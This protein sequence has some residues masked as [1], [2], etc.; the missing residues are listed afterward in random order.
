[1]EIDLS[2]I[3][4]AYNISKTMNKLLDSILSVNRD[5]Y[6]IIIINDGSSDNTCEIAEKYINKYG[7]KIKL[8]NKENGGHGSVFNCAIKYASGRY[9]KWIDGDDWVVT[10]NLDRI[11]GDL[12]KC[13]SDLIIN[14]YKIYHEDTQKEEL[15][16]LWID[17]DGIKTGQEINFTGVLTKIK[18]FGFHAIIYKTKILREHNIK[19]TE[20]VFYEDNEYV[21]YPLPYVKTVVFYEEPLYVYRVGM[22][23]QSTSGKNMWMRRDQLRTVTEKLLKYSADLPECY[24]DVKDYIERAIEIALVD[25]YYTLCFESEYAKVK[26]Y[27]EVRDFDR[28]LRLNYPKIYKMNTRKRVRYFWMAP[29]II[30]FIVLSKRKKRQ[31]MPE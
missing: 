30:Y 13:N 12:K 20:H 16:K 29:A 14:P 6:E 26:N 28:N 10:E 8:V 3:V 11:L 21:M 24:A 4:S 17:Y 27:R 22:G 2:I 15:F 19:L 25:C 31:I 7:T 23:E 1:M 5:N 9:L 18:F